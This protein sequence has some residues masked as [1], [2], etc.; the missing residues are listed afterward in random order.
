[1][2]LPDGIDYSKYN[3]TSGMSTKHWGPSYWMF[4][5]S[6]V[7]G[8]YPIKVDW[9]NSDHIFLVN[10]FRS[11][12]LSLISILPCIFCRESL[13]FFVSELPIDKF[14]DGRIEMMYWLYLIK[15]KVNN[16]LIRQEKMMLVKQKQEISQMHYPGTNSYNEAIEKCYNDTFMTVP[17]PNFESVLDYYESL[18]AV[19]SKDA[20]KCIIKRS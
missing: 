14:L 5:F 17:S 10:E 11:T 12:I 2:K 18:R 20:K 16:K 4:L 9:N 3:Q 19:C 13:N 15:N 1:M 7:M 8:V 6:S